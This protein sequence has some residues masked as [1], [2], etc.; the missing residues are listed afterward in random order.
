MTSIDEQPISWKLLLRVFGA[1]AF[2]ALWVGF[3]WFTPARS[4]PVYHEVSGFVNDAITD[5]LGVR[6]Q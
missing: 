4:L 3:F 5:W 1:T 6:G 2:G